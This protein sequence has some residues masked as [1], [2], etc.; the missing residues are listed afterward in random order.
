MDISISLGNAVLN[1]HPLSLG[2][3]STRHGLALSPMQYTCE[4]VR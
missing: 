1:L 2:P 4:S 3:V